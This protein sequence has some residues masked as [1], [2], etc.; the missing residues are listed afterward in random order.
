[1]VKI[2][3]PKDWPENKFGA[4]WDEV[5]DTYGIGKEPEEMSYMGWTRW[6]EEKS[7]DQ[8]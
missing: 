1:L 6:F 7:R 8:E 5:H 2:G 3:H 4:F